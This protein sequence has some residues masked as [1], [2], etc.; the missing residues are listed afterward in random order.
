VC[1]TWDQGEGNPPQHCWVKSS[2]AG[3]IADPLVISGS[4]DP[5]PVSTLCDP[6]PGWN[7]FHSDLQDAGVVTSADACCSACQQLRGCNAWTWNGKSD[8]HCWC[9]SSLITAMPPPSTSAFTMRFTGSSRIAQASS[10]M[11]MRP[12]ELQ[13]SR[14]HRLPRLPHHLH[15][16]RLR[17]PQTFTMAYLWADGL[18]RVCDGCVMQSHFILLAYSMLDT[19]YQTH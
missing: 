9:V 16:H 6:I 7:C 17:L 8:Q 18:L 5:L 14:L 15:S 2:C 4:M 10:R 13:L 11:R 1:R 19:L 12:V 3:A